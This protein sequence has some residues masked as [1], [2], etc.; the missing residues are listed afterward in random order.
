[1]REEYDRHMA[2]E[3]EFADDD[4]EYEPDAEGDDDAEVEELEPTDP[5]DVPEDKGD[6]GRLELPDEGG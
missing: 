3:F 4:P 1:M 5:A 2:D 6:I